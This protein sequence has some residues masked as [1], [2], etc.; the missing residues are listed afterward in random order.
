MSSAAGERFVLFSYVFLYSKRPK[1]GS[2]YA[3]FALVNMHL[4]IFTYMPLKVHFPDY[5]LVTTSHVLENLSISTT[6]R[7]GRKEEG[8][9][10]PL[11]VV[12]DSKSQRK[13]LIDN[14]RHIPKKTPEMFQ[15]VII[16]KDLTQNNGRREKIKSIKAKKE[17]KQQEQ[18]ISP[19]DDEATTPR[20]R[21]FILSEPEVVTMPAS[22]IMPSPIEAENSSTQRKHYNAVNDSNLEARAYDQSTITNITN[23]DETFM[24]GLSQQRATGYTSQDTSFIRVHRDDLNISNGSF[25]QHISNF[26]NLKVLYTNADCLTQSKREELKLLI[27]EN[28]PDITQQAKNIGPTWAPNGYLYDS[29]IGSP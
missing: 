10:R 12:L 11:R 9:I 21:K 2:V 18:P 6:Y 27:H 3:D 13:Y 23:V 7:L 4:H 1:K 26:N 20:T 5:G 15:R 14:A 22:H 8:K 29:Y 24:G 25:N 16:A 19:M 17:Q 28:S